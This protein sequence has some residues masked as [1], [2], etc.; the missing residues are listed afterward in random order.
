MLIADGK[1][2][3]ATCDKRSACTAATQ[4]V[5]GGNVDEAA[6]ALGELRWYEQ[7]R[8]GRSRAL[9]HWWCPACAPWAG[10]VK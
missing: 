8:A 9:R 5:P 2:W 10:K 1:S 7:A 6:T 4:T 3:T